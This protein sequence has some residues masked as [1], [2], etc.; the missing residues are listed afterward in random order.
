MKRCV[1]CTAPVEPLMNGHDPATELCRSC[2][3]ARLR[4]WAKNNKGTDWLAVFKAAIRKV[5]K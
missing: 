5:P 1:K 4:K 3:R 2:R